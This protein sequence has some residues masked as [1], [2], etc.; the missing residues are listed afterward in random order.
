MR[1]SFSFSYVRRPQHILHILPMSQT[2]KNICSVCLPS[3]NCPFGILDVE[4]L[5]F[6]D[7][8]RKNRP[9][10]GQL[11]TRHS[12]KKETSMKRVETK[13]EL[14]PEQR[15]ELLKALSSCITTARSLTIAPGRSVAR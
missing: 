6:D 15:E 10:R 7:L 8:F 4:G 13:K 3:C 14:S 9:N 5:S 11:F 1:P 2:T 12:D